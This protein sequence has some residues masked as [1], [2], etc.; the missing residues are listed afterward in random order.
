MEKLVNIFDNEKFIGVAFIE[1]I[2]F[3]KGEYGWFTSLELLTLTGE[4]IDGWGYSIYPFTPM[5]GYVEFKDE[6][7]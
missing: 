5:L 6:K 4:K 3:I 1:G 2:N 7:E